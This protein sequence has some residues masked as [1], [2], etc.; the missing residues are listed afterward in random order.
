[1]NYPA[2]AAELKHP[3]YRGQTP[4]QVCKII[5]AKTV[6]EPV[7]TIAPS[8]VADTVAVADLDKLSEKRAGSVQAMLAMDAI[9]VPW[10]VDVFGEGQVRVQKISIAQSL[11]LPNIKPGHV[12]AALARKQ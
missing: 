3:K 4:E 10:L 9:P 12:T 11:G 6:D 8:E 2:L 5:N 1:M 7:K